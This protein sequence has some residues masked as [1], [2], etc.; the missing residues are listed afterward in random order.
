VDEHYL[1]DPSLIV[2]VLSPSTENIDRREKLLNYPLIPTLHEYVLVAQETREITLHRREDHWRPVI[3]TATTAPVEFRS[4][5]L[6]VPLA[7]VYEG[8]L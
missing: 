2:E 5:K 7:Q 3:L 8:A 4:I 1:R 6:T